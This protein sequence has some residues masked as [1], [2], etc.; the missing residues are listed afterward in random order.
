[1]PEEMENCYIAPGLD[2]LKENQHNPLRQYTHCEIPAGL[3]G[4]P[5]LTCPYAQHNQPP[6][7]TFQTN[8][9]KQTCGW[10]SLNWP[11]RIDKHAFLQYY[12]DLPLI[13]TLANKYIYSN[14]RNSI[15]AIDCYSGYNM[16]DSLIYNSSASDRGNFKGRA[17][18][19]IK[20]EL[21]KDEKFGNPDESNTIIE[22]KHS[23]FSKIQGGLPKKGTVV[24][25][26]DIIIG[27]YVEIPKPIDHRLYRETSIPYPYNESAII[28]DWVK[29]R[30]QEDEEFCKVKF[31]SVRPLGIGDKFSSRSGQKGV[32]GMGFVQWDMPFT[33]EG[34]TPSMILNPAAIPSRMTIGQL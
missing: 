2:V 5:A 9:V 13:K 17:S 23:N 14:G 7:I 29:A 28:D 26:D 24:Y 34:V 1:S 32:T 20:T 18:N 33:S 27:K 11:H 15:V 25:K 16:E 6:R 8:Q 22:K 12:C 19:F 30:N 10:Y 21:E 3:F 4:L 31:S